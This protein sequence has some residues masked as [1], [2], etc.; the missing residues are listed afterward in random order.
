MEKLDEHR[1]AVKPRMF[2]RIRFEFER[3][4]LRGLYP[5][6]LLAVAI[7]IV[8]SLVAGGLAALLVPDFKS[9]GEAVW[10]AF[11][12]LT[13]PGYLGDDEGLARRAISTVVTVLGYILF[14]GMLIAILTQWLNDT[15]RKLEAGT[16]PVVLSNHVI[17]LGWTHRT[18]TIVSE[19]LCTKGRVQRFLESEG[20]R[21]LRIVILAEDVDADMVRT[22]R[23][24]LGDLWN[25]RQVLLRAG[26]PLRLDHLERVAFRWAA[27][28]VVLGPD[29]VESNLEAVDAETVK[30]LMSISR[31]L[32]ESGDDSPLAVVEIF[33]RSREEVARR[34]YGG[35]SAVLPADLIASRM[36]LQS[37]RQ[38]GLCSVFSELL[39]LNYG[40]ALYIRKIEGLAGSRFGDLRGRFSRAIPLG[41]VRKD[42]MGPDLNP[43]PETL[44]GDKDFLV[45]IARA[46]EDCDTD[47]VGGTDAPVSA[48]PPMPSAEAPT[49]RLLI[50]GWSRKVP[51]LLQE[52]ERYGETVFEID[53][54]S[55]TPLAERK[56]LLTRGGVAGSTDHVRQIEASYTVPEVLE[57]L[58]P[59]GYDNIILLASERLTSTERADAAT[60]LAY[61]M[62]Q[63][64]LPEKGPRPDLFVEVLDEENLSL[65]QDHHEDVIVSP[66]LVCYLLSQVCLLPELEG[67]FEE[68]AQPW[69]VQ[70]TLQDALKYVAKDEPVRFRDLE[71]AAAARGDIAL[72]LRRPEGPGTNLALNPDREAEWTLAPGDQ[73]VL[74]TSDRGPKG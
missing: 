23:E 51:A 40:N 36:I 33:D 7:V 37:V 18:P 62:L 12:R 74:L 55:S 14:L 60:V 20:A 61:M 6:I 13:D 2:D 25:D 73:V 41:T 10:W 56:K 22:L 44:I 58:E 64:L 47:G 16:S 67:V 65:F 32:T 48:L 45:L 43:H 28:V 24:Q 19:L 38:R 53:V 17:L 5:R 11:L 70:M 15:I 30:T 57:R 66:S 52:F 63:G 8:V 71:W 69:G 46:F 34:A 4:L 1:P 72:G 68:L 31:N 35:E 49:R 3:L 29:F 21:K 9:I 27:V 42:G 26:T 50:L 59:Q 54:V 39:T